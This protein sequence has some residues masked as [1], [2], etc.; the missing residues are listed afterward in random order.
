MILNRNSMF[1]ICVILTGAMLVGIAACSFTGRS[2]GDGG[3]LWHKTATRS[4]V[5]L[6]PLHIDLPVE[7]RQIFG[8]TFWDGSV[9]VWL[10]Y[11]DK[12]GFSPGE[13][14]VCFFSEISGELVDSVGGNVVKAKLHWGQ[15]YFLERTGVGQSQ[16]LVFS[17]GPDQAERQ[18]IDW[19]AEIIDFD[20]KGDWIVVTTINKTILYTLIGGTL[21]ERQ[22]FPL[23]GAV[24]L[25]D[26]DGSGDLEMVVRDAAGADL[27]V[28]RLAEIWEPL[29]RTTS[30]VGKPFDGSLLAE[31]LT[32]DGT[33]ELY[34]G[35]MSDRM[36]QFVL[37]T[38]GLTEKR[39]NH[40]GQKGTFRAFD[41]YHQKAVVLWW[42]DDEGEL[43]TVK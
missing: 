22:R 15:V 14:P 36:Q 8:H 1:L 12:K 40:P 39:G 41:Y 31:D 25:A 10:T 43:F 32:G 27:H 9:P 26:L 18:L 42:W 19:P 29:W 23:G 38:G 13:G 20:V 6:E 35:N 5:E 17:P 2:A 37:T 11:G 16:L 7:V 33:R 34:A 3:V 28:Y 24:V 4:S 21:K 30:E